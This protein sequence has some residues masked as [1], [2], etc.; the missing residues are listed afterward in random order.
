[1]L[2]LI[3]TPLSESSGTVQL[4]IDALVDVVFL[5]EMVLD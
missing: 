3:L 2:R 4:E 1:M 5:V